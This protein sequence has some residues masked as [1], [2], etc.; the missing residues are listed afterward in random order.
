LEQV[1]EDGLY[2]MCVISYAITTQK[3]ERGSGIA[4][5]TK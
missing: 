2:P 1:W 3:K 4:M 5:I